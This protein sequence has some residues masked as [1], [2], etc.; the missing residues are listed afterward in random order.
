MTPDDGH[1]LDNSS[2]CG[3]EIIANTCMFH[4]ANFETSA[5][6]DPKGTLKTTRPK[7]TPI[8]AA[9]VPQSQIPPFCYMIIHLMLQVNLKQAP[10]DL[11]VTLSTTRSKI[12]IICG[13]GLPESKISLHFAL[14]PTVSDPQGI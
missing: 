13:S 7:V 4:H 11:K 5:L 2:R 14:S 10:N 9:S 6:K 12:P 3:N 1:V 8:Y